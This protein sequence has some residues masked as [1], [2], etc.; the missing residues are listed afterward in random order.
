M[1]IDLTKI[2]KK[3]PKGTK[4]YSSVLGEIEFEGVTDNVNYPIIVKLNE[5]QF[6]ER[7]IETF[8]SDGRLIATCEGECVLFPSRDQR[9][10]SKFN[11]Q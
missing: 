10:W 6:G 9:D 4:L 2:L 3:C 11:Y 5:E 8:T 1:S 7:I